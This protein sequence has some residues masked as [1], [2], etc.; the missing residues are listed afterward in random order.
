VPVRPDVGQRAS[1]AMKIS[2]NQI[3]RTPASTDIDPRC[4]GTYQ[5]TVAIERIQKTRLIGARIRLNLS[6]CVFVY[7]K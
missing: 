1:I 3:I 5:I 2:G 4:G 6:Q 7:E